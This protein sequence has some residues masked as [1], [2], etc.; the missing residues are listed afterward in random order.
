MVVHPK[1][2]Q[3]KTRIQDGTKK[4]W[5]VAQN[6]SGRAQK[7]RTNAARKKSGQSHKTKVAQLMFIQPKVAAQSTAQSTK[8]KIESG[9]N[10]WLGGQTF[11]KGYWQKQKREDESV[12]RA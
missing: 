5:R 6:E 4:Y 8:T 2:A 11:I 9:T 10:V 3:H 7:Q 12:A 1:V